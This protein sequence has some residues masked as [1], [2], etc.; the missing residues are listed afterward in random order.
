[1]LLLFCNETANFTCVKGMPDLRSQIF[2]GNKRN[3]LKMFRSRSILQFAEFYPAGAALRMQHSTHTQCSALANLAHA[4]LE[5]VL[6][7]ITS[8]LNV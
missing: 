2:A 5:V 7:L 8:N 4:L 6:W 1:M 3:L